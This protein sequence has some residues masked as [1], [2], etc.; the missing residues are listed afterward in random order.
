MEK[1]NISISAYLSPEIMK[2]LSQNRIFTIRD[3]IQEDVDK[4][5]HITRL[6]IPSIIEIRDSIFKLYSAPVKNGLTYLTET[7][8]KERFLKT[9]IKSLDTVLNGGI[10]IGYITEVCGLAGSGKTQLCMQIAINCVNLSEKTVLYI[11]TKGD[12]SAV[13]IQKI[14]HAYGL[15]HKEMAII[16]MKI[17]IVYIWSMEELIQLL[18]DIKFKKICL[19][20]LSLIIIDSLPSLMFQHFGDDNKMGLKFL[21]IF[22]NHARY[23]CQEFNICVLCVNTETRWIDQDV[24]DADGDTTCSTSKENV[25]VETKNRCL[26]KY[27]RQIP[28]IVLLLEKSTSTSND[29]NNQ[30]VNITVIDSNMHQNSQCSINI[31]CSGVT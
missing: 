26:G 4:L 11:D 13:R 15:S 20:R 23:L 16:M 8:V 3:F 2:K 30:N 6:N 18:Q 22:V 1:L 7:A 24:P 9:G 14:L 5:T 10:P 27:W 29:T 12:F 21:N 31:S 28:L 25:Y 19:D 17:K